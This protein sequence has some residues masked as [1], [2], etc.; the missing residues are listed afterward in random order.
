[1][2]LADCWP[3]NAL[4]EPE[5]AYCLSAGHL[6]GGAFVLQLQLRYLCV[7]E[8][9]RL[10]LGIELPFY[11]CTHNNMPGISRLS[12]VNAQKH[13]VYFCKSGNSCGALLRRNESFCLP[14]YDTPCSMC[15]NKAKFR[16]HCRHAARGVCEQK[17]TAL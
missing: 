11:T 17:M 13:A 14:S 16:V 9:K 12:S 8:C 10:L 6:L 4:G 3:K 15:C 1:M 5:L 2:V 7:P